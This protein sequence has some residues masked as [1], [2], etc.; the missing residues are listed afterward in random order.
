MNSKP[1]GGRA[2]QR[3][4]WRIL[5]AHKVLPLTC[6]MT[7]GKP[8]SSSGGLSYL[9]WTMWRLDNAVHSQPSLI[10]LGPG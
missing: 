3:K 10:N 1:S 8:L 5:L 4:G 2:V 7:E 6:P 9:L